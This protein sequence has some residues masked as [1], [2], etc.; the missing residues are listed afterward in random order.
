[1]KYLSIAYLLWLAIKIATASSV[2]SSSDSKP[3]TFW[4]GAG[5]QWINPKSWAAGTST[6][7]TFTS[8]DA[9]NFYWQVALIAGVYVV[10]GIGSTSAWTLFGAG[11]ARF[12]DNPKFLKAFNLSMA[13]LLVGSLIVM[14]V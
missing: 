4:Q 9:G 10:A 2:G 5:F 13:A 6:L 14:F 3:L 11:I 1:M 7:G 8:S 12:L